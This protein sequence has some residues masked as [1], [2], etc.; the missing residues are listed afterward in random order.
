[1]STD[2]ANS[3]SSVPLSS[4]RSRR[5][6][7]RK[8]NRHDSNGGPTSRSKSPEI[9]SNA[10]TTEITALKTR[11]EEIEQ[12]MKSMQERPMEKKTPRRRMRKDKSS[13][14]ITTAA[15]IDDETETEHG[16][17]M[18][19]LKTRLE[20]A[21]G[22]LA[23]AT[24]SSGMRIAGE[25]ETQITPQRQVADSETD[26][27]EEI[28]RHTKVEPPRRTGLTRAVTLSGSYRLPIPESITDGELQAMQ[29]GL[30]SFQ[31]IARKYVDEG[32]RHESDRGQWC[33]FAL[34]SL[35]LTP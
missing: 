13:S 12:K 22:E 7:P 11:V 35:A 33:R 28:P 9:P 27:V 2:A 17:D 5:R 21:K 15:K 26:D 30:R 32:K 31:S 16:E 4:S 6:R 1:M 10:I 34:I 24:A 14:T 3:Q 25:T 20:T 18:A 19:S 23:A 29:Q 8:L